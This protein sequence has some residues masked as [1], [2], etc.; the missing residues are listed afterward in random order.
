MKWLDEFK[1]WLTPQKLVGILFIAFGLLII[2]MPEIL[3]VL[4]ASVFIAIGAVILKTARPRDYF[5]QKQEWMR[6]HFF[7]RF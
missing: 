4:I 5:N 1:N 6:V 3:I 7:N 2:M